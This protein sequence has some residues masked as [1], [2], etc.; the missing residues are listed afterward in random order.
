MTTKK[1]YDGCRKAEYLFAHQPITD[2]TF[3]TLGE[4][5]ISNLKSTFEGVET[6]E[7][8]MR[9][10]QA[11]ASAPELQARLR[12]TL[13]MAR[14]T[15][16]WKKLTRMLS[17]RVRGPTAQHSAAAVAA[18]HST[19]SL[20][21]GVQNCVV[22]FLPVLRRPPL[23][24]RRHRVLLDPVGSFFLSPARPHVHDPCPALSCPVVR[25]RRWCGTTASRGCLCCPQA[26]GPW[27]CCSGLTRGRWTWRASSVSSGA[28]VCMP[29]GWGGH[30][31]L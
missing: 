8:L 27:A 1:G 2:K 13:N 18:R 15:D 20:L 23:L 12:D 4:T 16:K 11:S 28:A 10:V 24:L 21:V 31:P 5:T 14:D 30:H 29:R 22:S 7:D 25:L 26:T 3:A 9:L 19:V 6:V 17:E